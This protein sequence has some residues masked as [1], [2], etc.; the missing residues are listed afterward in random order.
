MSKVNLTV[1]VF[2]EEMIRKVNTR[3]HSTEGFKKAEDKRQ[4]YY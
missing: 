1:N 3:S 2:F 4:N